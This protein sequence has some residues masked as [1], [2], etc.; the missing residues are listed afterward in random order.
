MFSLGLI[1]MAS[2]KQLVDLDSLGNPY[3]KH[4]H[5]I[6]SPDSKRVAY[7]EDNRRGGSTTIYQLKDDTFAEVKLPDLPRC[8]ARHVQKVYESSLNAEHWLDANTLI[9]TERSG[10]TTE[11]DED[12]ECEKTAKIK[13]DSIG[14]A[15]IQNVKSISARELGDREKAKTLLQNGQT[16]SEAG[17]KK[18]AIADYAR[19]IKLDPKNP[20]AYNG[21]GN[22]RQDAGDLN[23]AM[24]DY[25]RAIEI[26]PDEPNPYYNRGVIYFSGAI[27]RK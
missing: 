14:R 22:E 27:G 1:D 18:G 21:R 7:N 24:A 3:A 23:G 11:N 13:F 4:S 2:H 16:K 25:N 17:D 15:S 12:R 5:L 19:A 9:V 10:W 6:W 26:N 20:D 8:E